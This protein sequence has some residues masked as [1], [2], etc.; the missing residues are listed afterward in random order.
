MGGARY[1]GGMSSAAWRL[2][3][4]IALLTC[5]GTAIAVFRASRQTNLP[6]EQRT[7]SVRR[8][9]RRPQFEDPRE[10]AEMFG[11]LVQAANRRSAD[12]LAFLASSLDDVRVIPVPTSAPPEP[13]AKTEAAKTGHLSDT[14]TAEELTPP[15]V[16]TVA[17][18]AL[19]LTIELDTLS[20]EPVLKRL[21]PFEELKPDAPS[22]SRDDLLLL[23]GAFNALSGIQFK[24]LKLDRKDAQP[25]ADLK[26]I[27]LIGEA[28]VEGP[29]S[30]PNAQVHETLQMPLGVLWTSQ[31]D[32]LA[33]S[34]DP[35]GS[36]NPRYLLDNSNV[37]KVIAAFRQAL[38]EAG[39]EP[40]SF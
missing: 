34:R 18:V 20:V 17:N 35:T 2:V 13:G 22:W 32:I 7:S 5:V 16:D 24:R 11:R 31:P 23:R 21:A 28:R 9:W 36:E 6:G 8:N 12:D 30:S 38:A 10:A 19:S 14:V 37:A 27:T 39:K 1:L 25:P 3:I 26:P 40:K 29:N 15:R 4:V 33:A